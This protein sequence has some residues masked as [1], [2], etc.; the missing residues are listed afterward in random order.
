MNTIGGK[1]A[2][3]ATSE[4]PLCGKSK[5]MAKARLLYGHAVCKKCY[6]SF[7][8]RRQLAFGIDLIIWGIVFSVFVRLTGMDE[9][10]ARGLWYLALAVFL[11]KDGFSGYSPGKALLGLR[12]INEVNGKPIGFGSSFKR[13]LP[14]LVPFM[15]LV[16]AFQ[17]CEGHRTGDKWSASKVIW[18]QYAAHPIFLPKSDF[19]PA[20]MEE[21]A[22]DALSKATKLEARGHVDDA[23][24]AYEDITVSFPQTMTAND[25][26]I[27]LE[28]LKKRI[29]G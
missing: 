13:N 24:R 29:Q 9:E 11:M 8:N 15:P 16:I 7:A 12:T 26:K 25:A 20:E 28:I 2:V 14:T 22:H 23:L 19:T 18:K 17:L 27:S 4:C 5:H 3:S 21:Q 10:E 6:Y 1:T